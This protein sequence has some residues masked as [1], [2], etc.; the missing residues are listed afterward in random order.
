M[1]VNR[2]VDLIT[3]QLDGWRT[4]RTG[5]SCPEH[6]N[7]RFAGV[8]YEVREQEALQG[9]TSPKENHTPTHPQ[10]APRD[11][12][13]FHGAKYLGTFMAASGSEAT[14]AALKANKRGMLS[15][16]RLKARAT[17]NRKVMK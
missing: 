10:L 7:R 12:D 16:S 13:V 15:V 3:A 4:S 17:K 8:S 11:Y 1:I 2:L 5:D 9:D 6:S 14:L